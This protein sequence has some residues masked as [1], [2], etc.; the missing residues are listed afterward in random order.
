MN[1]YGWNVIE[2]LISARGSLIYG[3]TATQN[4]VKKVAAVTDCN[5]FYIQK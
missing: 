4:D 2:Y 1:K 3:G 5:I